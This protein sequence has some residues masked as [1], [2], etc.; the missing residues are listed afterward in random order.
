MKAVIL[1][2]SFSTQL[3]PLT[4]TLP[5]P[6][7]DFCNETLLSHQLRA[8][9]DAGMSEVII[10]YHEHM[11]PKSWDAGIRQLQEDVGISITC[12]HEEQACARADM[13][14]RDRRAPRASGTGRHGR[15]QLT[16]DGRRLP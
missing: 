5:L 6:L 12:S 13:P 14:C 8:L 2:G 3:R 16:L 11:V 9:K 7:L 10:C 4:L 1:V 15:R